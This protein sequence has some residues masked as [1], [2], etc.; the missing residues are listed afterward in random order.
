MAS[1]QRADD[2]FIHTHALCDAVAV[3]ERTRIWAFAHILAGAQI[4]ADCNICDH[5]FIEND[6]IIGNRVT[7]KS[8]VQ[9]WNGLRVGDDVFIGPN[10]TFSNDKYPRSKQYQTH[11]LQ[12]V[13]GTGASVGAG[14]VV[15]PGIRIGSRAMI[16]AG[17]VVT[18]DVPAKAIV[19]G[20]PARIVGYADT[21]ELVD[22]ARLVVRP[23]TEMITQ[24]AVPPVTL[25]QLTMVEDLRGTLTA[26]EFIDQIPFTPQRYFVVLDVPGK[27]VRGEHAHR[28][29]H[30]FLV[31]LKG[32]L[33][34]VVDDGTA[35]ATITLREANRGLY[36]PP[37]I[38]AAQLHY[39]PD[40]ILLVLA[41][42]HYDP[43]DYIRDYD[44]FLSLTQARR[45]P[46]A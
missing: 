17:A 18:H 26:G 2:V 10:A 45:S 44:E 7:V 24:T 28:R 43:E 8:G 22:T 38:W 21:S 39:S 41:S 20:N 1:G 36:V 40:A 32:S 13:I 35:S 12:T 9:L 5:V 14:A 34:V 37:L 31:C 19:S 30:Q 25:H 33:T 6:V 46:S 42:E 16:G 23:E 29:C 15:L 27:E 4:G 11:V 3:G